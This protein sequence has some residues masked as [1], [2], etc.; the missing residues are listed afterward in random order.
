MRY[1]ALVSCLMLFDY[2]IAVINRR[3]FVAILFISYILLLVT[4]EYSS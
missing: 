3:V 4:A 2:I 1:A